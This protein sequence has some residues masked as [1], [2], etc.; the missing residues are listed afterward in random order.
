MDTPVQPNISSAQ[1]AEANGGYRFAL[2][3]LTTLFFMWGVF[4]KLV[5]CKAK[6]GGEHD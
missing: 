2:I 6:N 3:S 4:S 1:E 5:E